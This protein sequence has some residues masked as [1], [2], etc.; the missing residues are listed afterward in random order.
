[1]SLQTP[2]DCSGGNRVSTKVNYRHGPYFLGG[3]GVE[4]DKE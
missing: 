2:L 1:M 4:E 3:G